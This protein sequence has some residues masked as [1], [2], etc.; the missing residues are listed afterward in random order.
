MRKQ[1]GKTPVRRVMGQAL[2][3]LQGADALEA[4]L[5]DTRQLLQRC[6]GQARQVGAKQLLHARLLGRQARLQLADVVAMHRQL[7]LS[8]RHELLC[9]LDLRRSQDGGLTI[10]HAR[11][12]VGPARCAAAT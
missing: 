6:A 9:A 8:R 3:H 7:R 2:T 11:N 1:P 4:V 12:C 10:S 5:V